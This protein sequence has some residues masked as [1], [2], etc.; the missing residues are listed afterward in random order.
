MFGKVEQIHMVGIGGAGMSGIAEILLQLGYAVSGSDIQYSATIQH[1]EHLGAKIFIGH[2]AKNIE[3]AHVIVQSNAIQSE[4]VELKAAYEHNIP[5]I[6]RA[7]MLAEL[8]RLRTGIAVGGTHGKTTTTSFI[9]SIFQ[10]ARQDPTVIIGGKLNAYGSNAHLGDSN[11][12]IVEADESDASFLYLLPTITTVTNIDYDHVDFYA[13]QEEI[14]TVFIEFLNKIPFYGVN[15]VCGDDPGIQRILP[16]IKRKVFTY[17]FSDTN[18][19]YAIVHTAHM[20]STFS[21]YHKGTSI[22]TFTVAQP[23]LH[24]ILNALASIAVALEC[25]L[26]LE[27]CQ[28]GLENFSGVG[29]R[30]EKKGTVN[31]I[32]IIDDY[33]H[34]PAEIK[35]TLQAA[36]SVFPHN[37]I[38]V[39]FQ[40]HRF[41]RI[42]ALFGDFCQSFKQC[43]ILLLTEIYAASEQPIPGVSGINLAQGI[44]QVEPEKEVLYCADLEEM[45]EK[46][47]TLLKPG[48]ILLTMGAGTITT[49]GPMLI[50]ELEAH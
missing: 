35:A 3:N 7:E 39:A 41:S 9:A 44:R 31:N 13:S 47:L 26:P 1:L 43:D 38:V 2:N 20:Q 29:R 19:L 33:G 23:G 46:L 42:N 10:A 45:L 34:H 18:D 50:R 36:R 12:M 37:R 8:M 27:A 11:Y 21:A 22:G 14:D 49:L 40:P 32:T 15:V 30:F 5:V 24:N 25:N 17:G 4:N 6:P 16:Y 48:D 28:Q